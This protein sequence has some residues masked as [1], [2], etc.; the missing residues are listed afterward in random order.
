[1]GLRQV[2]PD[3]STIS[4]TGGQSMWKLT[5]RYSAG[6]LELLAEKALLK[7]KTVGIEGTLWAKAKRLELH[8][9]KLADAERILCYFLPQATTTILP[10]RCDVRWRSLLRRLLRR[11]DEP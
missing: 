8:T 9:E 6:W 10:E 7:G 11:F 4:R 5:K 1:V 2:P 3:R